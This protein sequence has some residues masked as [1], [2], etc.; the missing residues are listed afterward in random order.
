MAI[1]LDNLEQYEYE[2]EAAA[3]VAKALNRMG[4]NEEAFAYFLSREHR[5]L[6]QNA[7]RALWACIKQW[8][9]DYLANRYDM[10]NEDTVQFAA[11]IIAA[12]K[13]FDI[14]EPGFRHV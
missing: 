12:L 2:K 1:D 4:F 7:A 10:R 13:R 9:A 11:T 3:A 8:D 6:Q 14:P 5:T